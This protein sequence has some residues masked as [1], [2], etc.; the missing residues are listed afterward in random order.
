MMETQ[1]VRQLLKVAAEKS[2]EILGM[3]LFLIPPLFQLLTGTLLDD[4]IFTQ[5]IIIVN[6]ALFLRKYYLVLFYG[7]MTLIILSLVIFIRLPVDFESRNYYIFHLITRLMSGW[8]I[9]Y[10]LLYSMINQTFYRNA[11]LTFPYLLGSSLLVLTIL[12]IRYDERLNQLF[13]QFLEKKDQTEQPRKI[14]L[15]QWLRPARY[16]G[17]L[18]LAM[19]IMIPTMLPMTGLNAAPPGLPPSYGGKSGPYTVTKIRLEQHVPSNISQYLLPDNANN[20]WYIF[21]YVPQTP[22]NQKLPVVLYAH[23]YTGTDPKD[24]ENSLFQLASWGSVV[25]FTQYVTNVK[26]GGNFVE[27]A[28]T[29]FISSNA[30]YFRYLMEWNGILQSVAELTGNKQL[31]PVPVDL[32]Y[33]QIIGH[34]VGGGMVPYL[35]TKVIEHGWASKQLILDMETPW[36]AA[37]H[38]LT[39]YNLSVIPAS[40]LVTIVGAQDDHLASPCI[41]MQFFEEFYTLLSEKNLAYLIVPSDYH[42]FPRLVATHYYLTAALNDAL[43]KWGYLKRVD[44]MVAYLFALAN[45]NSIGNILSYFLGESST[46]TGMGDWSDATPVKPMTYSVDPFGQRGGKDIAQQFVHSHDIGPKICVV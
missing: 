10:W 34:S 16:F 36:L 4:Y 6:A 19:I 25:I 14:E 37:D 45:N 32:D 39:G 27:P 9:M 43:T 13:Q 42:G 11:V 17:L 30:M 3:I 18:C 20:S 33:I 12:G 2:A 7:M 44:A 5:V 1:N 35:A 28:D 40:T 26:L 46:L 8:I 31:L 24:Y 29:P 23:G 38:P 22:Q 15:L 21:I 41:G